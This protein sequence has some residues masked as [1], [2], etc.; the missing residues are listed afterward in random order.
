MSR[1]LVLVRAALL[2]APEKY[3]PWTGTRH[4]KAF[5]AGY[6]QGV[7]IQTSAGADEDRRRGG[8]AGLC[9]HARL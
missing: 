6:P 7:N 3:D 9:R 5:P 1:T 4:E 8:H 2:K